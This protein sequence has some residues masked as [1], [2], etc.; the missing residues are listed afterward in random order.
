METTIIGFHA[1]DAGDWVAEL[2]CGHGQHMR[3]KPPWQVRPWV[4]TAEGRAGK[5]GASIE[6]PLCDAIALPAG[7][8]EYKR[9]AI[10]TEETL[11]AKLREDHRTKAGTWGRIVV[12]EGR[13]EFHARGHV[14]V[15]DADHVGIVEPEVP[16]LVKPL[17]PVRLHVEFWRVEDEPPK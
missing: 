2:G 12:S 4:T 8:H 17:G 5:I 9:T 6:C 3:H 10:F 11:P 13:A 7:A 14:F 15:L 16:H 1:D